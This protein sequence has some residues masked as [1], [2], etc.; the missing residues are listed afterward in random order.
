MHVMTRPTQFRY[1]NQ[2]IDVT[3]HLCAYRDILG[4]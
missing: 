3:G 4:N 2:L 1:G